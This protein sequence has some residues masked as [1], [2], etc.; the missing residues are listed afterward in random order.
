[1]LGKSGSLESFWLL[2]IANAFFFYP[3]QLVKSKLQGESP[4]LTC[5]LKYV[6]PGNHGYS[7]I[8]G[9]SCKD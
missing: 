6:A 7:W 5:T 3:K 1:M 4:G 9:F 8:M 2:V